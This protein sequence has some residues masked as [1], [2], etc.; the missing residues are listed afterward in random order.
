M[1]MHITIPLAVSIHRHAVSSE[2]V[3]A[4][5]EREQEPTHNLFEPAKMLLW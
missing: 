4:A 1:L 2:R 3:K 5:N